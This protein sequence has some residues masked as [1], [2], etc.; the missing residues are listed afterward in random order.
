M[1]GKVCSLFKDLSVTQT[2]T[3]KS[4]KER[5]PRIDK[6]NATIVIEKEYHKKCPVLL[7]P[8]TYMP[9]QKDPTTK[10]ERSYRDPEAAP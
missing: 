4:L 8:P 3:I 9:L 10:V 7:Q 1:E 2:K 6:E 5:I